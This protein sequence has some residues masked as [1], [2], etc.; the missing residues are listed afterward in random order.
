[1]NVLALCV[2]VMLQIM[3]DEYHRVT[4]E[5]R[6]PKGIAWWAWWAWWA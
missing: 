1:M 2:L 4:E 6:D 3:T 5:I